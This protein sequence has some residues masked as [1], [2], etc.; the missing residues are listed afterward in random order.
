MDPIIGINYEGGKIIKHVLQSDHCISYANVQI[1]MDAPYHNRIADASL[2]NKGRSEL[3]FDK[4]Y[5]YIDAIV[6]CKL[7]NII[8]YILEHYPNKKIIM[9]IAR[10][11]AAIPMYIDVIKPLL[12]HYGLLNKK[13]DPNPKKIKIIN[14]Y[15]TKDYFD[16]SSINTDFIF[17]NIG[18]FAVLTHDDKIN[19][20]QVCNPIITYDINENLNYINKTLFN[21]D[22]NILNY[23][24]NIP[25]FILLGISDDMPFITPENYSEKQMSI[26]IK[27]IL[28]DN[29]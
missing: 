3:Q 28:L 7:M 22:K 18:M 14:G 21:S 16:I 9:Q 1:A 5:R 17:I 4:K 19:V 6:Q 27:Q 26:L 20:G 15:R 25:K 8:E 11:K 10:G 12:F 29:K 23:F 24:S 13:D 2:R